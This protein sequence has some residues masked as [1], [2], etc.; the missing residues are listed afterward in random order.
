MNKLTVICIAEN[1]PIFPFSKVNDVAILLDVVK[2]GLLV[3]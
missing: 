1:K 2:T 3:Q